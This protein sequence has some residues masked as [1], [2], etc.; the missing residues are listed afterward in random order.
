MPHHCQAHPHKLHQPLPLAEA[1]DAL[2]PGV[3]DMGE[4][5]K[6]QLQAQ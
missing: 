5:E 4:D 1:S 6:G 2:V 3:A